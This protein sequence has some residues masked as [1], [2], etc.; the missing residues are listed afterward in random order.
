MQAHG[1]KAQFMRNGSW[2]LERVIEGLVANLSISLQG[3]CDGSYWSLPFLPHH[4]LIP[5]SSPANSH[6]SPNSTWP[7]HA[8]VHHHQMPGPS[9]FCTHVYPESKLKPESHGRMVNR[10]FGE[11]VCPRQCSWWDRQYKR[12]HFITHTGAGQCEISLRSN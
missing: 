2:G 11:E 1:N 9:L 5:V 4:S 7:F 10:H 3:M 6:P 8:R 12:L